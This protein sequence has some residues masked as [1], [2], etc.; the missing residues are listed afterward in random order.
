MR[1][2]TDNALIMV[3]TL[4]EFYGEAFMSDTTQAVLVILWVFSLIVVSFFS[5]KYGF[6]LGAE[7]VYNGDI[8]CEKAL[9]EWVCEFT[10]EPK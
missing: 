6:H 8:I 4:L 5:A 9:S 1:L 2:V 3:D 10:K 7:A